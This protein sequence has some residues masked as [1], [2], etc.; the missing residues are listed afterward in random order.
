MTMTDPKVPAGYH[1]EQAND[2]TASRWCAPMTRRTIAPSELPDPIQHYY[3][4]IRWVM[5][6]VA[7]SVVIALW[8]SPLALLLVVL[9]AVA[10]ALLSSSARG[11]RQARAF[12]DVPTSRI[13]SASQ[14][15]VEL[16]GTVRADGDGD[17][18]APLS[19]TRCQ[20]WQLSA[21]RV[22]KRKEAEIFASA[23]SH[24]DFLPLEDG[25]G[26]CYVMIATAEFHGVRTVRHFDSPD[27][28]GELAGFFDDAHARRLSAPGKWMVEETCFP[29]DAPL[30][31]TGQFRS[32]RSRETPF[33]A[34]WMKTDATGLAGFAAQALMPALERVN[35]AWFAEM[36]RVEGIGPDAPLQG[37][38]QVHILT[39]GMEHNLVVKPILS[40]THE[41]VMARRAR[42][43]A[44]VRGML[45]LVT[46]AA[47]AVLAQ[48]LIDPGQIAALQR[49]LSG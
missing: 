37:S 17:R 19:G 21:W 5:L 18:H 16:K 12:V 26:T 8:L 46:L 10:G 11:F 1:K 36:R 32:L 30:Y 2:T 9:L 14:G 45:G 42:R 25:T 49:A 29:V 6:G 22:G 4:M 27:R 13:R 38:Q 28:L 43:G 3:R 24:P 23:R 44:A 33:E 41:D 31:A 7:G 34:G 20:F 48:A 47:A 39:E 35:S 15:Y 40:M